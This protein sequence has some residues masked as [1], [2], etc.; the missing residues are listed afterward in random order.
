MGKTKSEFRMKGSSSMARISR[1]HF[2]KGSAAAGAA[3]MAPTIIPASALGADGKT[4]PSNKIVMG[5]IGVGSMGTGNMRSFIRH[6]DVQIVGVCDLDGR[7]LTRAQEIVN[8]VYD[9]EDCKTYIDFRELIGRGDLDAVSIAVPDH[10]HAIPAIAAAKAGLD[11]YGEKPLSRSIRESRAICDAVHRYN[12][13]WQTGSWQRSVANFHHACEL[14]HNGKVGKIHTVEVGLPTGGSTGIKPIMPVPQDL[15]W[16]LWLGPAP[17]VPYREFGGNRCHWDWRWILDYSGGQL[18]DWAGHHID[19]AHWGLGLDHTGP[20]EIEGKA[21]YPEEGLYNAPDRYRFVCTYADGLKMHV[22]NDIRGGT[23]WIGDEGWVWVTRGGIDASDKRL[24]QPDAI[25][26]NDERLYKSN[27]HQRNFLDCVK[28]RQLTITPV[29]S[30][31]RS[32]SVGHLGEIAMLTQR[33]IRWNPATEEIIG[34]PQASA[35]LGR[36]YRKPWIL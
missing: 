26:P 14:V 2:I 33:K 25:G 18:T 9:N 19:I 32:I 12:R 17:K 21:H 1:R 20:V 16:D 8:S 7:H 30:A 34:D 4:A 22:A 23:K 11:I 13:V 27:D 15:E 10:W 3:I 28:S 24:L 31:C 36:A 6:E 35:L 29:E 5:C